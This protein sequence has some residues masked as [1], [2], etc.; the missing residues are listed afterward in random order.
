MRALYTLA[1]NKA[2]GNSR[3]D[4]I[5]VVSLNLSG[6]PRGWAGD[7]KLISHVLGW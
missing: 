7:W 3:I 5:E 4:I 6:A 2:I 1:S